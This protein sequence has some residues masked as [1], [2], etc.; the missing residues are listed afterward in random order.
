ME[1]SLCSGTSTFGEDRVECTSHNPLIS[2]IIPIYNGAKYIR[3]CLDSIIHQGLA[4]GAYE[5]VCID[6]C[7][8]DNSREILDEYASIYDGVHCIYNSSNLKTS[9]S[10]NFALNSAHGKYIWII[11][12]D[13]TIEPNSTVKLLQIC[14]LENLDVLAF[15]YNRVDSK[16]NLLASDRP[17]VD[18]KKQDGRTF[19]KSYFYDTF[20]IYLLGYEWRAIYNREFIEQHNIVFPKDTIYE[21][22]IFMFNAFWNATRMRTIEDCLYNYRQNEASVTDV[23]KRYQAF[24]I[25]DFFMVSD[26]VLRFAEGIDDLHIKKQL[27]DISKR[28][29]KSFTYT[30][31]PAIWKEKKIFYSLVKKNWNRIQPNIQLVPLYVR[32]LL[33]PKIGLFLTV[34]LK[35]LFI[36]K[37]MLKKKHYS[38]N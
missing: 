15:N 17:F 6:D 11:G 22:T 26:E 28:Y 18:T 4:N 7:S 14:E 30:I 19:I 21:D 20:C 27:V 10:L 13:D 25:F 31:T 38:N 24:R 33:Y 34:L 29:L 2:F 5:I 35:P 16:G 37:Q 12:Q 8:K 23:T 32:L 9:N 3:Q 36:I 1:K